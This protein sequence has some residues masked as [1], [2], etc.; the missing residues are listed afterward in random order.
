[1]FFIATVVHTFTITTV[2][3]SLPKPSQIRNTSMEIVLVQKRSEKTPEDA[4]YLAQANQEGGGENEEKIRPATPIVTPFPDIE[5]NV[6]ATPPEP[7]IAAAPEL[8]EIEKLMTEEDSDFEIEAEQSVDSPDVPME[9]GKDLQTTQKTDTIPTTALIM[10]LQAE[11]ASIQA[12]LDDHF[13]DYAK[14]PREKFVNASTQESKYANYM[15]EW[16]RKVEDV[17]NRDVR[18]RTLRGK[19]ILT[20]TLNMNGT[21][22][23]VE[24]EE[25]SGDPVIDRVALQIVHRASPFAPFPVE[26]Q[27]E[28]D[29]LHITRTWEFIYDRLSAHEENFLPNSNEE[30]L[31]Y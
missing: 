15:D 13:E 7:E 12:E 19:L 26:I 11:I 18:R 16:R 21:I 22:R 2:G 25:S 30:K 17:G 20:T 4:T 24:I 8:V 29:I 3:F 14:R 27:E 31:F 10:E 5:S 6:V 1:M 23:N 9:Q 28:T